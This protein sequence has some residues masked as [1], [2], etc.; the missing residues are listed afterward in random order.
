MLLYADNLLPANLTRFVTMLYLILS[1]LCVTS[2]YHIHFVLSYLSLAL[3]HHHSPL[4]P[5]VVYLSL[6][7]FAFPG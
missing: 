2:S 1:L 4:L 7:H 6:S 5:Y 3:F